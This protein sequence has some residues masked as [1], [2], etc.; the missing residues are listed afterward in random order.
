MSATS[1]GILKI[2]P[3]R[4]IL[5]SVWQKTNGYSSRMRMKGYPEICSKKL[6]MNC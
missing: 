6:H 1:K 4:E 5:L 3:T 2:S